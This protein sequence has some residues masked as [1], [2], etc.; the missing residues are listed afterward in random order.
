MCRSRDWEE[1]HAVRRVQASSGDPCVFMVLPLAERLSRTASRVGDAARGPSSGPPPAPSPGTLL[2][3]RA[4]PT[5]AA[6]IPMEKFV[7]EGGVP[8]SGTIVPA[9]NKN[10]GHQKHAACGI[11]DEEGILRNVHRSR[12]LMATSFLIDGL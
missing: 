6:E 7:I 12:E 5:T 8:L 1:V 11:T 3:A 10:G 4:R 9:G 2:T